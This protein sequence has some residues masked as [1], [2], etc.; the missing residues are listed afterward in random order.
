M[1]VVGVYIVVAFS[2]IQCDVVMVCEDYVFS[3]ILLFETCSKKIS[4][5]ADAQGSGQGV[6]CQL[7][8]YNT[9][10]PGMLCVAG[11]G[12]WCSHQ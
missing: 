8:P 5:L 3:T 2:C 1:L 11:L 12:R 6:H 4:K 7:T 10:E 9:G